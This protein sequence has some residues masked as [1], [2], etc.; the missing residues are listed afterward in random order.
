MDGSAVSDAQVAADIWQAA[1]P[2]APSS[3]LAYLDRMNL[4]FPETGL[5]A[6]A[7]GLQDITASGW[8]AQRWGYEYF[9]YTCPQC[10]T[11]VFEPATRLG[12]VHIENYI[13]NI[14]PGTCHD[15]MQLGE[16]TWPDSMEAA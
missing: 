11:H 13:E 7:N 5:P 3:M 4:P 6:A 2:H 1:Q 12:M 16:S 14:H 8:I 15:R 9:R 10:N